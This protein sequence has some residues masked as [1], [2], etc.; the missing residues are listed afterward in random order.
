MGLEPRLRWLAE[1]ARADAIARSSPSRTERWSGSPPAR[2]TTTRPAYDPTVQTSVLRRR[3]PRRAA[4]IGTRLYAALFDLL[5]REDVHRACAGISL[6]NPG[7]GRP[8]R[9][10]RLPRGRVAS[11]S[12]V[13]SSAGT[14]TSRG[15]SVRCRPRVGV[16]GVAPAAPYCG[17][18]TR[19]IVLDGE[20]T[21]VV[22]DGDELVAPD[23]RR[24]AGR[25][26][27][28]PPAGASRRRSSAST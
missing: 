7:L 5:A 3:A 14:G 20:P 8:P 28:A 19:R 23:G 11:P 12:R 17:V 16:G 15:S 18:E 4:A 25:T 2:D 26:R 6:P 21:T 9:A 22:R 24:V 10:V 1:H 27:H 13:A